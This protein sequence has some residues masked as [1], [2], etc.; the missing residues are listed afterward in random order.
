MIGAKLKRNGWPKVEEGRSGG[1]SGKG[2]VAKR[3]VS[4]FVS[5]Y[6]KLE[7]VESFLVERVF[8]TKYLYSK[9]VSEKNYED[10][11]NKNH[12]WAL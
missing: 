8:S 12:K 2:P 10:E 7:N 9:K 11:E 5:A 4:N 1:I 6:T 3:A